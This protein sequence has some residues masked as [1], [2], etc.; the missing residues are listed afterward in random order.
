MIDPELKSHLETI[1]KELIEIRKSSTS[2]MSSLSRG[3]VYG[4]GYVIGAVLIVLLVG[5]ILN[6]VGV[7]PALSSQVTEF[8][9]ALERVST[10]VK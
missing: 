5:W 2:L 7:I 1:E 3:L 10:P 6:I 9:E 4:M 8:R